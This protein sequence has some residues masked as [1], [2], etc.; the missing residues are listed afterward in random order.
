MPTGIDTG[1]ANLDEIGDLSDLP[2]GA[3]YTTHNETYLMKRVS[4]ALVG[5]PQGFLKGQQSPKGFA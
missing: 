4:S 5:N 3:R 1:I 2:A